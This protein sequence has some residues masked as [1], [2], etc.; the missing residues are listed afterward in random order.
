MKIQ[1]KYSGLMVK[2]LFDNPESVCCSI[3]FFSNIGCFVGV[4]LLSSCTWYSLR[5]NTVSVKI[6]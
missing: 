5:C 1:L 3:F 4:F 6:Q 2:T